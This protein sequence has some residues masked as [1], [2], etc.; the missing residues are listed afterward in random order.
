MLPA[1]ARLTRREDFSRTLRHGRRAGRTL[2][3][4][5]VLLPETPCPRPPR[6]GLV[7]S[8]AVGGSVVRHRVSR[9]LR[10]VM[11]DRL[12]ALPPGSDVVIRALPRSAG[13]ESAR[14]ASEVD[15]ALRVLVPGS[16]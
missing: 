1:T 15:R 2:V 16:S 12:S 5:H 11:K 9:Q 6:V 3:V 10:H 14:L 13:A 7:V 8:K 4:M